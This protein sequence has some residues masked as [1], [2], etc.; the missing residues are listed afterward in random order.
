M[1]LPQFEAIII[2]G[3]RNTAAFIIFIKSK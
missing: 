1:Q 2:H 3:E